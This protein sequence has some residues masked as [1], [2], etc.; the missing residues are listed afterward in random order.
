MVAQFQGS[1]K[2]FKSLKNGALKCNTV[3]LQPNEKQTFLSRPYPETYKH[4]L[5]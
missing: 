2:E 5:K 3:W 4:C 1:K